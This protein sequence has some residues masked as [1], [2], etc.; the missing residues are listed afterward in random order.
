M[1]EVV[2]SEQA[3]Q[4]CR[5]HRV[6]V[7]Y[8]EVPDKVR[9]YFKGDLLMEG[10]TL[11]DAVDKVKRYSRADLPYTATEDN[12]SET[13]LTEMILDAQMSTPPQGGS[14]LSAQPEPYPTEDSLREAT[15]PL[16]TSHTHSFTYLINANHTALRGCTCGLSFIGYMVGVHPSELRWHRV[17]E[18]GES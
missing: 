16:V 12:L 13:D 6:S 17:K 9:L 2:T 5:D 8:I 4:W 14:V 10:D 3:I 15:C 1:S 7:N 18:E 11:R